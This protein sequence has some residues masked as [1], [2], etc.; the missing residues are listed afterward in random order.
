MRC[1]HELG[2]AGLHAFLGQWAGIFNFLFTDAA[3]FRLLGG[4]IFLGGPGVQH[5]ARAKHLCEIGEILFRRIVH[6][7]RLLFGVEV[8]EIAKELIE[9]VN[10]G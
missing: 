4:I 2:V 1:S 7:F 5:T 6:V 8:V 10:G 9:A 3:P